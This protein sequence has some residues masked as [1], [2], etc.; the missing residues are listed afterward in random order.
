MVSSNNK[1]E[2]SPSWDECLGF[3]CMIKHPPFFGKHF[4]YKKKSL[5][6]QNYSPDKF[7][8]KTRYRSFCFHKLK[9]KS[10]SFSV[11]SEMYFHENF[12]K[13]LK[14]NS[15]RTRYLKKRNRSNWWNFT[16]WFTT[17]LVYRW[18]SQRSVFFFSAC[19]FFRSFTLPKCSMLAKENVVNILG[20][21]RRKMVPK[22]LE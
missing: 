20:L 11:F 13:R 1:V 19:F 6:F 5:L 21:S 4:S 17:W 10:S 15:K 7:N 2:K 16:G 22:I 3:L 9:H 14:I 8:C 18:P 12:R